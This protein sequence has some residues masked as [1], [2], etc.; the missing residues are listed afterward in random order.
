MV[1]SQRWMASSSSCIP[2]HSGSDLS[3][4]FKILLNDLTGAFH[5]LL[6]HQDSL[7]RVEKF[8]RKSS[9]HTELIIA[10]E[11]VNFLRVQK[12]AQENKLSLVSW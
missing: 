12:A 5:R 6:I 11:V 4:A 10:N 7:G 1:D 8:L 2:V 9:K 3:A